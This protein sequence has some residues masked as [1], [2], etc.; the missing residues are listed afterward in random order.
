[1]VTDT[2][3][4]PSAKV[5]ASK[6][7]DV[8]FDG[9]GLADD[10]F[11][12]PRDTT[13]VSAALAPAGQTTDTE[14]EDKFETLIVFAALPPPAATKAEV[15]AVGA[16]VSFVAEVPLKLVWLP[17]ASITVTATVVAPSARDEASIV[18]VVVFD[19]FG[20]EIDEVTE[21]P[22]V[23]VKVSE[24]L[25]PAGHVTDND[26]AATLE[27][28]MTSAALLAPAATLAAVGAV[29]ATVSFVAEDPLKLV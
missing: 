10:E 17:A 20:L 9:F 5:V 7:V 21:P 13:K 25:A 22:T 14:V 24:A 27:L 12:E 2:P 11:R 16:T 18:D 23:T 8:V 28:L 1:M 4:E 26:V 29:G 19:G 6:L 3:T 15:G